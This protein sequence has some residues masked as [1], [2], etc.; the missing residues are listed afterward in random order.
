MFFIL[1]IGL[2]RLTEPVT[3]HVHPRY[4][5]GGV[6]HVICDMSGKALSHVTVAFIHLN[7]QF[8]TTYIGL[9]RLSTVS[10]AIWQLWNA[11]NT[12]LVIYST[13]V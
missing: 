4:V 7:K 12:D 13:P 6:I 3:F 2:P 9:F 5:I 10:K 11:R 1:S 8:V